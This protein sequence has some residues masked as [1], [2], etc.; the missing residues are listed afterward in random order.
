MLSGRAL[1][2]RAHVRVSLAIITLI[3]L[4]EGF[5]PHGRSSCTALQLQA[6]SDLAP[7]HTYLGW[8]G[9]GRGARADLATPYDVYLREDVAL[10]FESCFDISLKRVP[11]DLSSCGTWN[12]QHPGFPCTYIF[13]HLCVYDATMDIVL[14]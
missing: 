6:I 12:V 10:V 9:V 4:L 1:P 11:W 8:H 3:L 13:V 7:I 5:T 2:E 14:F